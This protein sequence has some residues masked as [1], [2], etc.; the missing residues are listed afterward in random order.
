MQQIKVLLKSTLGRCGLHD[1]A[2]MCVCIQVCCK[3]LAVETKHQ[4]SILKQNWAKFGPFGEVLV[5]FR[6]EN[7]YFARCPS[8]VFGKCQISPMFSTYLFKVN[9]VNTCIQHYSKCIEQEWMHGYIHVC[10]YLCFLTI[11]WKKVKIPIWT[12]VIIK[13]SIKVCL[14]KRF[15]GIC[16]WERVE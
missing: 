6:P 16:A 5:T 12:A 3:E 14:L 2:C 10:E 15:M 13:T 7:M 4:K 11:K 9:P 8:L 1:E